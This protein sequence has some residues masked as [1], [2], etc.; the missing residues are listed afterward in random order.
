[1]IFDIVLTIDRCITMDN[2]CNRVENDNGTLL[3]DDDQ[4][5]V[6]LTI[7]IYIQKQYYFQV[8]E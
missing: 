1:M 5:P 3:N 7:D 4:F 8:R 6:Y 2:K